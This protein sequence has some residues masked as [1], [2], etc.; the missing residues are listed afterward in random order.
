MDYLQGHVPRVGNNTGE[1]ASSR[2]I[3]I[4]S[5]LSQ[6]TIK[7]RMSTPHVALAFS[8]SML[9][10]IL[11]MVMRISTYVDVSPDFGTWLNALRT[12]ARTKGEMCTILKLKL[13]GMEGDKAWNICPRCGAR[14]EFKGRLGCK[15]HREVRKR[16][17][18]AAQWQIRR[19]AFLGF[20]EG[21]PLSNGLFR[22]REGALHGTDCAASAL[23]KPILIKLSK[24][25]RSVDVAGS[26][27]SQ[28]RR[29]Q[30]VP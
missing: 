29:T 19:Q 15:N 20:S 1:N 25:V 12:W 21:Y 23:T 4:S 30:I 11:S 18:L 7:W 24:I 14:T 22:R 2:L 13:D 16:K 8:P 10:E 3:S 17:Q 5:F 28:H 9:A 6:A 27:W 26:H